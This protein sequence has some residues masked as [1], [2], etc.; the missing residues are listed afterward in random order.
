M[1]NEKNTQNS[2]EN[3]SEEKNAKQGIFDKVKGLFAKKKEEESK[4]AFTAVM[5]KSKQKTDPSL[6]SNILEK[7]SEEKGDSLAEVNKVVIRQA[8]QK[9]LWSRLAS[10]VALLFLIVS[11][12]VSWIFLGEGNAVLGVMGKDNLP[13]AIEKLEE[14]NTRIAKEYNSLKRN[15]DDLLSQDSS[16]D[17]IFIAETLQDK[18]YWTEQIDLIDKVVQKISPYNP[19]TKKIDIRQYSFSTEDR[20]ISISGAIQNEAVDRIYSLIANSVDAFEESPYFA[21]LSF[22][23]YSASEEELGSYSSSLRLNFYIQEGSNE[24]DNKNFLATDYSKRRYRHSGYQM[25]GVLSS[26]DEEEEE[27]NHA[28]AEEDVEEEIAEEGE[29]E[30]TEETEEEESDELEKEALD[31]IQSN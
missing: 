27:D 2:P 11:W 30:G 4:N 14:E 6:V 1:E 20:K 28:A 31:F 19:V 12:I 9:L 22:G 5:D 3:K 18:I 10:G 25:K 16:D 7:K 8:Q 24:N 26:D 21:D 17:A 13:V 23:Q 29:E 15:Y